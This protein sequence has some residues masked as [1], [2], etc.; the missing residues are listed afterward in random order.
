M[1]EKKIFE[2]KVIVVLFI[3]SSIFIYPTYNP[4]FNKQIAKN[5]TVT[6]YRGL[7]FNL[8]VFRYPLKANITELNESKLLIGISTDPFDLNF[9]T[10]P[11]GLIVRKY[12]KI[13]NNDEIPGIGRIYI[14]GN[15]SKLVSF[16][17]TSL[18]INAFETKEIEVKLNATDIGFYNGEIDLV[19]KKPSTKLLIPILQIMKL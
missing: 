2:F 10:I 11:K 5:Q 1:K 16:S 13:S 6:S 19:I 9:G 12:L 18:K 3:I 4:N 17:S 8:I 15:I 14:K 7:L